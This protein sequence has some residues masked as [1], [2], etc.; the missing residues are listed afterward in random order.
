MRKNLLL[1]I[2]LFST[3]IAQAQDNKSDLVINEVMQSNVECIMDDIH[4]FPDSW[5][6]LYNT[7]DQTINLKDYSLWDKDKPNKAWQL[8]DQTV[9]A[10]QWVLV[11]CDKEDDKGGM[12]ASFRLDSGKAKVYLFKNGERVDSIVDLKKQK[13]PDIAYGRKTDGSNEWGYQL[14]PTPG[15]A[16]SGEICDYDHILGKPVFSELGRVT[17]DEKAINLTLNLPEDAPEEAYITYTTNGSEPTAT[18]TKYS[19]AISINKTTVIRAK[20]FC[21][22]W[23][24]PMSTAQSYIFHPRKMTIPIFSVQTDDRYLNGG[25]YMGL[26]KYNT[27]K[28]DKKTHDWRRPVNIEFFPVE[29][30]ESAFNQLGETRIQGGQSRSNALKSMVFYANK[31]FDPDNKRFIYPFFP[32][33]K[34]GISEF[35][36]FSLRDGGND[37]DYLYFRDLIIQRTMA[38]H[39]DLDWQAGHSAVL[40]INGEYMGMLNIRERSNADNIFSNY[41]GLE[42]ID[43]VE[44]SHEKVNNVDQFIEELKEGDSDFYEAFKAFYSE[45]GHTKE[46]YEEWMDVSEYLNVMVM[47]LYYGNIDFPGNNIVFWRPNDDDT[48]SGLPKKFRV[49]VK[50]TDFGL[51]LYN[52]QNDYN[53]IDLLYNPSKHQGD[54]WAC[55][56]P[57]TR[58]FKNMMENEDLR[59]MFIDKS[60]IYMGDFM[61]AEGTG[62]II[63]AI[64]EEALE[65]FVAHRDKYNSWGNNRNDI[66]NKFDSAKKWLAGWVEEN[67]WGGWGGWPWG[68]GGGGTTVHESRPYHFYAQLSKQYNLGDTIPLTVN[69]KGYVSDVVINDIP[70]S[71]DVFNGKYFANRQLTITAQATDGKQINGWKVTMTTSS[72]SKSTKK[73][74]GSDFVMTIPKCKSMNIE[75][76]VDVESGIDAVGTSRSWTWKRTADGILVS[77]VAEGISVSLHDLRGIARETET[78]T[79][80][81]I[82]LPAESGKMYLLK[83][84][85]ETIKIQ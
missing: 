47:N 9:A 77:G 55:T 53:T 49:I 12:H 44:I 85:G 14:T 68:G 23:L 80:S 75:A 18:G 37:F 79:G 40:Y 65:E 51:G 84:G 30:E 46:E 19:K 60:S 16:N 4:E 36:S 35:K 73:I 72:G 50:D 25:N 2:S 81:D 69:S 76:I 83:V 67:Q 33:Q 39:V 66:L 21:D 71:K 7:T 48:E 29:G 59:Q 28:D 43:M 41:N 45:K 82:I 38:S 54:A 61:N 3:G 20:V 15:K 62:E 1:L 63:D 58:L 56:E 11:Y 57:A 22:G 17:S 31:R 78:S 10:H 52:R 42:D 6:E 64:K 24:S 34:P 74:N 26:F 27:S 70:L 13:S 32:D 8:P 5:V